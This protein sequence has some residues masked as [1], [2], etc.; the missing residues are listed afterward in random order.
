M[1]ANFQEQKEQNKKLIADNQ[2]FHENFL[3]V[4]VERNS[5][6]QQ[7]SELQT[8]LL[9]EKE[10]IKR[11]TQQLQE[12]GENSSNCLENA[13]S[14]KLEQLEAAKQKVDEELGENRKQDESLKAKL[15]KY[16]RTLSSLTSQLE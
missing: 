13:L 4:E 10:E 15:T 5:L 2:S 9:E 1:I 6:Q 11:M 8:A 12:K 14:D 3:N 16:Q 7:V